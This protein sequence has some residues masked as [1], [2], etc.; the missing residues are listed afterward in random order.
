KCCAFR[1]GVDRQARFARVPWAPVERGLLR[2]WIGVQRGKAAL[3]PQR[4]APNSLAAGA[5]LRRAD[6]DLDRSRYPLTTAE[7]ARARSAPAGL[8]RPKCAALR[9]IPQRAGLFSKRC[10]FAGL[11][12]H[13]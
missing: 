1:P 7:G 11:L 6:T 13:S 8:L 4:L 2:R 12:I 10:R 5:R 3:P 9:P